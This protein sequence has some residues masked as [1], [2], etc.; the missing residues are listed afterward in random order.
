M[1]EHDYAEVIER[2]PPSK[3]AVYDALR[4]NAPLTDIE[5][6]ALVGKGPDP[7]AVRTRRAELARIGVVRQAGNR[8]KS[9]LWTL[10]PPEDVEVIAEKTKGR[11]RPISEH[12][13]DVR[14]NAFL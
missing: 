10:A 2:L 4:N 5:L 12:P 9:K 3:R 6:H 13:L 11:L 1:N 7:G 14:V 8:G